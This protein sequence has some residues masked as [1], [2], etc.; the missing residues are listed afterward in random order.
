[1]NKKKISG[2]YNVLMQDYIILNTIIVCILLF[3]HN[4]L[5]FAM[6]KLLF[7]NYDKAN[8]L[9]AK[10]LYVLTYHMNM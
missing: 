1:M 8:V 2:A 5:V 9:L 4:Y 6:L 7:Q 3:V 10:R